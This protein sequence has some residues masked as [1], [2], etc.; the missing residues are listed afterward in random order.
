MGEDSELN[1]TPEKD[2]DVDFILEPN[3]TN[4]KN[5]DNQIEESFVFCPYCGQK[6]EDDLTLGEL[7]YNTIS[8]Y[9]SFDARFL[10]SFIPLMFRPGYVARQFVLGKRLQ[11]L[12]PAQY[13]LFIS[14]VFFFL[15]SI[16]VREMNANVDKAL[17]EGFNSEVLFEFDSV[18]N[19][20]FD[21]LRD[22]NITKLKNSKVLNDMSENDR[23]VLDSILTNADQNDIPKLTFDYDKK[24]VD[25]L[26]AV[27][28]SES[29]M[30]KAMGMPDDAG[31]IKK[32]FY[33]QMLKFQKN[34]GGGIAQAFFDSLPIAVFLLLP[35]FAILLKLFYWRRG[36]FSHHL[37][38]SLYY[39][40]FL[41]VVLTLILGV[42]FFWSIPN[43]IDTLIMLSTYLYF[44][45][46][47]RHF[48]QQG[49]F[50]SW[51]KSGFIVFLCLVFVIPT[52]LGVMI[53]GSFLFY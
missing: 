15:F 9:F 17:K 48:Y 2:D 51:I 39:F 34:S 43:W 26:I 13:Y 38:F 37:V 1:S 32:R 49:F 25:S 14:V 30:L 22:S 20:K 36:R 24:K 28:A 42:N 31:F 18:Q 6:T 11:Y 12:H 44:L 53:A 52:A 3:L 27:G 47:L 5:C 29:D 45:L 21:S 4:C 33:Q 35:L 50:I 7:F 41:F 19:K 40:S 10:R 46:A 16:N 8:N 23:K